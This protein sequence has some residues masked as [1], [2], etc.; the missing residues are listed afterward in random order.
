MNCT[1]CHPT[2]GLTTGD[3]RRHIDNE[4]MECA[5]CHADVVDAGRTVIGAALPINR[6]S[7]VRMAQGSYDA[8]A[9]RCSNL[10]CHGSK[11]W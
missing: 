7:D 9:Q 11:S 4:N 5:E 6:E 8:A 1:S 2:D 3:H 10:A